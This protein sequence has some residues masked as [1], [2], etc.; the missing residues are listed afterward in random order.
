MNIIISI[1]LLGLI[2][3]VHELGHFL[4]ARF[5]KIPVSEFAIGMGPELYSYYTGRTLYSLRIIP[6]GGFVNIEGMEE[7]DEVENGFSSKSPFV[8]LIVLFAGV[9]MNFLLGYIVLL[10]LTF[11]T[12]KISIEGTVIGDVLKNTKSY[13]MLQKDDEIKKIDGIKVEKW[14][15]ILNHLEKTNLN[16]HIVTVEREKHELEL[17]V[18]MT[19]E[20]NKKYLGIVPKIKKEKYDIFEGIKAAGKDFGNIFSETFK[21][22][23]MLVTGKVKKEEISGPI[24]IV[25]I[26]GEATKTGFIS[27]AII[28]VFITIN[29]GIFNLLPFPALDGG[30]ILFV[31]LEMIGIKISKSMEEKI[32]MVGMA[33]LFGVIILVTGNDILN[34]FK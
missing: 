23:K 16:T 30:R 13:G 17:N 28:L 2:I 15:D 31:L 33:I 11:S 29:I 10:I 34:I 20:N 9:F 7:G 32:H 3:L 19:Q 21:G 1:L 27:I 12:G 22:L 26:V 8:R 24:G 25:K 4:A 18:P 14:E 6:M 5:F